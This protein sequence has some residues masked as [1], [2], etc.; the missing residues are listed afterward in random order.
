MMNTSNGLI[1][2]SSASS[3]AVNSQSA[4][5]LKSY[6]KT[7]EGRYKLQYEKTHP[8]GLLHYSHGKTV[9]QAKIRSL[10]I[11][12]FVLFFLWLGLVRTSHLANGVFTWYLVCDGLWSIMVNCEC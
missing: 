7:P 1:S 10:V 2:P 9:S 11:A 12:V 5:S 8:S 4:T 6:F 3:G